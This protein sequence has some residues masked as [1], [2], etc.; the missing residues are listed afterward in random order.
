M[1]D[2]ICIC[3]D[4]TKVIKKHLV[5][6]KNYYICNKKT[7]KMPLPVA[8][9]AAIIAAAASA[10][11]AGAS[12][13]TT[14]RANKKARDQQDEQNQFNVEQRD[15]MNYYNSPANQMSRFKQAGL[16][17]HLIYGRGTAGNQSSAPGAAKREIKRPD[18]NLD[19]IGGAIGQY[20]EVK[21]TQADIDLSDQ[22]R[23]AYGLDN[24]FKSNTMLSRLQREK[25]KL[26]KEKAQATNAEHRKEITL[27]QI[28]NQKDQNRVASWK[29]DLADK[30]MGPTDNLMMRQ[31]MGIWNKYGDDIPKGLGPGGFG[32]WLGKFAGRKYGKGSL[33]KN[34]PTN[35]Y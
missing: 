10:A 16:N 6:Q 22:H 9:V 5:K 29:G 1:L 7:N 28:Q 24:Y 27:L 12:A 26:R 21:K 25:E 3:L 19:G 34:R 2:L 14:S 11:G 23:I 4:D 35:K 8:I 15:Y 31:G 17:P 13:I 33:P 18:I 30:N 20:M 32:G